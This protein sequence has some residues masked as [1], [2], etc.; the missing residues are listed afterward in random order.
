[1]S[2]SGKAG[3][4]ELFLRVGATHPACRV[5]GPGTR[6]VIWVQGCPLRCRGCISPQWLSFEGGDRRPVEEL[7]TE[8]AATTGI[9]GL[10]FS[11][12]EPFAQAEALVA[13]VAAV[14]ARR[15]LSVMSY[16]GFTVKQ[17]RRGTLWQ[18]RL[19]DVC[20]LVIDGPY[21]A[22]LHAD[23]RWRGSSNQ[24]LVV[25]GDR[26][27]EVLDA[28][29]TSA[30]LQVELDAGGGVVWSGVPTRPG[31]AGRFEASLR[32]AGVIVEEDR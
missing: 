26:H 16:T 28:P 22:A 30:G 20:D 9:D 27:A 24:R 8:I 13:L 12:G 7:A 21:V 4:G 10:T 15:D 1:M 6:Y 5:L 3:T 14:R 25:L 31:F 32:R 11:G 17:L 19:L 2:G 23:L 18:R 29:D